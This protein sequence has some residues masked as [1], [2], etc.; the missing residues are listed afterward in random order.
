MRLVLINP[1]SSTTITDMMVTIAQAT[2]PDVEITGLTASTGPALITNATDLE[3][4]ARA[5]IALART[6]IPRETEGVIVGAFGDP[7]L[8]EV[9]RVLP[10]PATGMAEAGMAEAACGGRRFAVVTT[11]PGLVESIDRLAETYGWRHLFAGTIVTE[12]EPS[13][14]MADASRL[15]LA[16]DGAC[17][18]AVVELGAEALVIGGGPLASAAQSLSSRHAGIIVEPLPAAVRLAASRAVSA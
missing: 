12:G 14:V 6:A 17:R 5:V 7:G 2:R 1:N 10:C 18:R 4:S 15:V 13:E 9:Q 16:L 8:R 11:T 3:A